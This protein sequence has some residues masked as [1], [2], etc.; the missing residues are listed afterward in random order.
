MSNYILII[1]LIIEYNLTIF[2][3]V[4]LKYLSSNLFTT[5]IQMTLELIKDMI[6]SLF[7]FLLMIRLLLILIMRQQVFILVI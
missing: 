1:C 7:G 6:F 5:Q 3:I 4:K 2:F